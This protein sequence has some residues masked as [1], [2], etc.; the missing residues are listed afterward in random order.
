MK[1]RIIPILIIVLL[2]S[3]IISF[4]VF[5]AYSFNRGFSDDEIELGEITINSKNFLVYPE[6]TDTS[7][8]KVEIQVTDNNEEYGVENGMITCYASEKKGYSDELS[9]K[10]LNRLGLSFS[11][12]NSIDVY[13]RIHIEDAW[14]S[15]KVYNN[16]SVVENY[17]SKGTTAS[18]ESPFMQDG[19]DWK[20]DVAT[21]YLYYKTKINAGTTA[22][23]YVFDVKNDYFYS[24][25]TVS[26]GFRES[27]LVQVSYT[28]D[29]VQANRASQKWGIANLD[30]FLQAEAR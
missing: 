26:T 23:N 6:S 19:T 12:T 20:Y 9:Y 27:I 10:Y 29:I 14:V 22:Q 13:A 28:I 3:S 25:D 7:G 15:H 30:A 21:G 18:N 2:V 8:T 5:A 11:F 16:G 1:K 24:F 17:I 4:S